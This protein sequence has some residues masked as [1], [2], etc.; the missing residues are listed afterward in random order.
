ME[1][2]ILSREIIIALEDLVDILLKDEYYG[3][4]DSAEDYVNKIYDFIY[5][6]PNVPYKLTKNNVLGNY[7][8]SYKYSN[9]TTWYITFNKE[10][11]IYLI[12]NIANNHSKEY[13]E[14]IG[15]IK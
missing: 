12:K 5:T 13:A 6:I 14:F 10:S 1:Q 4:L 3:F 15:N 9:R 11:D 7:Y 2:I 8:C